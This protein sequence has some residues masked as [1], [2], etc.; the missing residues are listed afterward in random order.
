MSEPDLT[1]F[2]R[3]ARPRRLPCSVKLVLRQLKP[4]DRK[5][6]LAA[7][8]ADPELIGHSA[9]SQWLAE[10]DVR[11]SGMTISRHRRGMCS[12]DR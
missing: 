1:E 11:V 10:R 5:Q 7:L 9:I 6:L 8:A 12:C 3:F 4:R 2:R